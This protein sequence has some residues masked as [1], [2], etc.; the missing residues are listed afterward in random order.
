MAVLIGIDGGVPRALPSED[1]TENVHLADV[2]V[3]WPGDGWPACVCY[4]AGRWHTDGRF[5]KLSTIDRPDR[6]LLNALG[7]ACVGSRDGPKQVS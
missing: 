2:V 5:E 1:L 6:V 4:D 7:K 3:G